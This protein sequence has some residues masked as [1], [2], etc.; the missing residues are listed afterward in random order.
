MHV[1]IVFAPY[2]VYNIN[3]LEDIKYKSQGGVIMNLL[4]DLLILLGGFAIRWVL[5]ITS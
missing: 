3:M 5:E 4:H 2:L 1:S